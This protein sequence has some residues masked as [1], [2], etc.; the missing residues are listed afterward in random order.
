MSLCSCRTLLTLAFVSACMLH[1]L[2]AAPV[3][4]QTTDLG[5][6]FKDHG[7]F[8]TAAQS[9]GM[10]CTEDGDGRSVVLVWLFDHR[11]SY[12]LGVIDAETGE[13]EEI[14]RPID[15]D[16]PF[17]SL[18]A[19]NGRYYTYFGGHFMEFDPQKREFTA[20]KKGP[21]SANRARSMT[22]DDNGV[23]WA[24]LSNNADVVSYDPRTGELREYG[25][26]YE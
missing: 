3:Y 6:G 22:E 18:L 10:V 20:V 17:A 16:C 11:Y 7:P 8:S 13:I 24:G 14:P 12:A 23:I 19:E 5:D 4:S 9:R 1:L 21:E 15:R 25:P 26:V 2:A